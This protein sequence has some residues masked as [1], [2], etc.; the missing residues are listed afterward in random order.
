VVAYA[1]ERHVTVVPEIEMPGHSSAA[2]AAYPHLGCSGGPYKVQDYGE[3][4]HGVYCAGREETFAFLTA[5]LDEVIGLFPGPYVHIGGDE[6]PKDNW[7][8]C[9]RCRARMKAEGLASE[10]ELQS[11]F[12]RRIERHL[13]ARGR[14]L[15]G[16]SE[17]LQGGLARNAVVMD[18]IGGGKEAAE[19][20]HGAV[21]TPRLFCYLD[22]RQ[23]EHVEPHP[24]ISEEYLPW[25]KVYAFEP[26]P[27]GLPARLH[28]RI[29]GGQAS[30]WTEYV[31]S[32]RY[33]QRMTLPRLS[34]LA[35]TVWSPRAARDEAGFRRRL[36]V[37]GERL[38]AM[39]VDWWRGEGASR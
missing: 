29:L 38:D 15:V 32:E 26:V 17:I 4:F 25:E 6:A 16:W 7:K 31:A 3:V 13:N 28:R 5:V 23:E 22:Y 37:Q 30:L 19:S 8:A 1:A 18:W 14:T 2:L 20:G 36:E 27:E 21:M 24:S 33:A 9:P 39:G 10:E 34:A 35:E 11:W 12:I